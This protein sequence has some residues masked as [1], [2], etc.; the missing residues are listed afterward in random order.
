MASERA[1]YS[2]SNKMIYIELFILRVS[3]IG[4]FLQEYHHT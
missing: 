2:I 3:G 1:I 4:I